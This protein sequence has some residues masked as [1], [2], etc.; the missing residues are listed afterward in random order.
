[1]E[2][3]IFISEQFWL[4]GAF[5]ILL[6]L[7][8]WNEKRRGGQTLSTHEVTRL[9][10]KEEAILVDVRDPADYKAGHIVN[11]INIPF[12]KMNERWEELLPYKEKQI[13]LADKM[14]QHAGSVGNTLRGKEFNV[15]RLQGGM[16]E[17]INQNLPIV[18]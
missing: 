15:G 16:M 12:N 3:F 5:L 10:N 8:I 17:W 14:G 13:V 7:F 9:M 18:K 1:M 11:A 4:V 2:F 6:Y